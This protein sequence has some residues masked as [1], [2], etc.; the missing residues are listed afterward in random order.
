MGQY[1]QEGERHLLETV[2]RYEASEN[3]QIV[4]FDEAN[5]DGLNFLAGKTMD[6][7][8]RQAMDGTLLA[9]EIDTWNPSGESFVWVNVPSL[10]PITEIKAYWGVKNASLRR[11]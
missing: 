6:F 9:H 5:G 7:I 11:R 2:V 3:Q 1:I 4:P 10:S 8:N